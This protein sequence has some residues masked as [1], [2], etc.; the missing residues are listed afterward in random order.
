MLSHVLFKKKKFNTFSRLIRILMGVCVCVFVCT[1][2]DH[3]ALAG[4]S[5][6]HS[7]SAWLCFVSCYFV[8]LLFLTHKT[9]KNFNTRSLFFL[10]R[11]QFSLVAVVAVAV[12]FSMW[13]QKKARKS[14]NEFVINITKVFVYVCTIKKKQKKK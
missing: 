1:C 12:L 4:G 8:L 5:F 14:K 9:F 3:Q 6:C 10:C 11:S 13:Q 7:A 2:F